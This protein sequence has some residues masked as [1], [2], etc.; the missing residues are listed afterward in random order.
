MRTIVTMKL[1]NEGIDAAAERLVRF[2]PSD[3]V[4]QENRPL[5]IAG[6]DELFHDEPIDSEW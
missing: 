1:D 2:A 4:C 5:G 6:L 3:G